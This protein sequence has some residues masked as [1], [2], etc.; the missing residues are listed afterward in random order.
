MKLIISLQSAKS[1]AFWIRRFSKPAKPAKPA[2][3]AV[4]GI[5]GQSNTNSESSKSIFFSIGTNETHPEFDVC[6]SICLAMLS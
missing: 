2:K 5:G 1:S 4:F 6:L 3:L